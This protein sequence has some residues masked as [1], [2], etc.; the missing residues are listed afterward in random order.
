VALMRGT[1]IDIALQIEQRI[2]PPHG[3]QAHRRYR[4]GVLTLRFSA[5]G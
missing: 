1:A 3:F 4:D 2:D 5:G